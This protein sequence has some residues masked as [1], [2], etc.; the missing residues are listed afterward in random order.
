[1]RES[2]LEPTTD[3]THLQLCPQTYHCLYPGAIFTGTQKSGWS[4]YNVTITITDIDLLTS[5]LCGYFCICQLTPDW[6][7]LTTYFDA[8]I[9]GSRHGFLT[10]EWGAS[11]QDD[12][13]FL[14]CDHKVNGISGVDFAGFYYVC[15]EFN[16]QSSMSTT[17]HPTVVPEG[18]SNVQ[19]ASHGSSSGPCF[20]LPAATLSGF[21]YHE[22]LEP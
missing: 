20:P 5:F 8:E 16:L 11:D 18:N 10:Q 9:I 13:R 14:V 2:L 12:M 15:M 1:M 4:S 21:Y 19:S 3:I 6:P 22:K 7:E 17:L